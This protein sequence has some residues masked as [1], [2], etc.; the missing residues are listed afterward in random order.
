MYSFN[1][2][3]KVIEVGNISKNK[4]LFFLKDKRYKYFYFAGLKKYV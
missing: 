3:Q 2:K 1:Y 4:I